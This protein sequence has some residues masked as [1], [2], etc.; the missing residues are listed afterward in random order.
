MTEQANQWAKGHVNGNKWNVW[1]ALLIVGVINA[2]IEGIIYAIFHIKINA[3][4]PSTTK[5]V[6]D[7][8]ISIITAPIAIGLITYIV[9]LIK[10]KGFELEQLF[11]KFGQFIRIAITIILEKIIVIL[12][13]LLL[14]IPG[15]IRECAYFLTNY[16]LAD[17]DFDDLSSTQ[18]LDLSKRI[19]EGNKAEYFGMLILWFLKLILGIFTLGIIWIWWIP[20]M[21]L[22][23]AKYATDL[24]D[25]YKSQ[26]GMNVP[27]AEIQEVHEA[28]PTEG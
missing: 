22:A 6:A 1:K 19:M 24:I 12:F 27:K 20:E 8:I 10:G 23:F 5:T 2:V 11:S 7:F 16:I 3:T 14:I 26:N 28:Q 17:P 4:E 21:Q 18:I 13:T 15:I 25:S 9:N